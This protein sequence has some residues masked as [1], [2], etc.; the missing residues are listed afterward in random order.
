MKNLLFIL[1]ILINMSACAQYETFEE[2]ATDMGDHDVDLITNEKLREEMNGDS[3]MVI[4]DAR[5]EEEYRVSHIRGAIHV[6][7]DDFDAEKVKH[8]PKNSKVV[9]YCS[10]GYRSGKIGEKLAENGF[11]Q[12]YNLYGGIFGWVN[13]GYKIVDPDGEP[14]DKIHAYNESWGKWLKKGETVYR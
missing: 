3:N 4:L 11:E 6:G 10:V 1:V 14:T 7:Y 8:L 5:S 2:M 12:V 9:V 13:E